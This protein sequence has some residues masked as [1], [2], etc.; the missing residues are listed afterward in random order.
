MTVIKEERL[1][2][3]LLSV[4]ECVCVFEHILFVFQVF[5][6][7]KQGE[8]SRMGNKYSSH[9]LNKLQT[10]KIN[11]KIKK[12]QLQSPARVLSSV[13]RCAMTRLHW[14][15]CLQLPTKYWYH[16]LQITT[17]ILFYSFHEWN[18]IH[19]IWQIRFLRIRFCR[20]EWD[21]KFMEVAQVHEVDEGSF[22]CPHK[23]LIYLYK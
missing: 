23:S 21:L 14:T 16:E 3:T 10:Y 6:C 22:W 1:W 15:Q 12:S 11:L 8:K 20:M 9:L 19:H 4:C 13:Q 17:N 18:I 2:N 5:Q 7:V